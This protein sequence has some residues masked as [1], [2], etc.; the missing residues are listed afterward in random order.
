MK[1]CRVIVPRPPEGR[2]SYS[3]TQGTVVVTPNGDPIPSI[4]RLV[5]IADTND[6]W[7]AELHMLI[8]APD[9]S[10]LTTLDYR[11]FRP[12]WWIRLKNFLYWGT[13]EKSA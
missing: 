10:C 6:I 11:E 3:L 12:P 7:R 9:I 8:E 4:T 1:C 13:R 2:P 5:L